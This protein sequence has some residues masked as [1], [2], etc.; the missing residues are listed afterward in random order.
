MRR[1]P[2]LGTAAGAL[3]GLLLLVPAAAAEGD[4]GDPRVAALAEIRAEIE[5]LQGRLRTMRDRESSLEG[6]LAR[7]EL[8]LEL[9]RTQLAEA[10]AARD[11]AAARAADAEARVAQLSVALDGVRR[12]LR[13][14][15]GGL[16]LLGRHGYLRLFLS[17]EPD[18]GL[19]PALRQLRYLVRRDHAAMERYRTARR[20]LEEERRRLEDQRREMAAWQALEAERHQ[21]LSDLR[22]RQA[23]LLRQVARQRRDLEAR[24]AS[25]AEKERKLASFIHALVGASGAPLAGKP[26]Q[27]FAGVLDWPIAGRVVTPFG[28]RRDPRYR[29]EVPHHGIDLATEAGAEVRAIYPGKV[30]F[31]DPF[32][33]YGLMV[34]VHHPGRVFTLYSGLASIAVAKGDALSLGSVLGT[35]S[36]TLYFEIRRENQPEDPRRWLR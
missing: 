29:T 7:T 15:L 18:A 16:Y 12:D 10:T 28:P 36:D 4:D 20:E 25:L 19:L 22:R 5:R 1:P 21:A 8:E 23:R 13:Q 34:V 2:F 30:L 3:L 32:E 31:A 27:D 17:L 9:Q 33:G 35:A 26:I 11:L 6:R 24:R 14:R